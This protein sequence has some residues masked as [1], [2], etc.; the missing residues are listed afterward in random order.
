MP[1]LLPRLPL[2]K[3]KEKLV[4]KEELLSRM[5]EMIICNHTKA[6]NRSSIRY[7]A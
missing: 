4:Y 5:I 3:E 2:T 7:F 6:P 1:A